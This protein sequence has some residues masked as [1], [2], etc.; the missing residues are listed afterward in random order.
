M[1]PWVPDPSDPFNEPEWVTNQRIDW[2]ARKKRK[3]KFKQDTL[4]EAKAES[5][6]RNAARERRIE[7]AR[8]KKLKHA[9]HVQ[10]VRD[11]RLN[12]EKYKCDESTLTSQSSVAV[13]SSTSSKKRS[14]SNSSSKSSAKKRA[15]KKYNFPKVSERNML[16]RYMTP[17]SK[18]SRSSVPSTVSTFASSQ[19]SSAQSQQSS[20]ATSS[21]M[22]EFASP[23]E[24]F[25][26]ARVFHESN[27]AS[28]YISPPAQHESNQASIKK[29]L[30]VSVPPLP[31]NTRFIDDDPSVPNSHKLPPG[32]LLNPHE[33]RAAI[34]PGICYGCKRIFSD[35]L[36]K[37][38]RD[39]C[40][41]AVK[42]K[43]DEYGFEGITDFV[44]RKAYHDEYIANL[45]RD[46]KEATGYYELD[47][48]LNPPMCMVRGSLA[49][50]VELTNHE[51]QRGATIMS[52][53]QD[54]AMFGVVD[55]LKHEQD[56]KDFMEQAERMAKEEK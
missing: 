31:V 4:D 36:E 47:G 53:L 1:D 29:K 17:S 52:Y 38:Y 16:D 24:R 22:R 19:Q 18:G 14:S 54:H 32:A 56:Y 21:Q 13:D 9:K 30:P 12:E 49:D 43:I 25:L 45:R 40:L 48:M 27:R 3:Q 41:H 44:W 55:R 37:K 42:N 15:T 46:L 7:N 28:E 50:A 33:I 8:K 5:I 35:C 20:I 10:A 34:T 23:P 11:A 26:P 39:L 2:L 6:R 51:S